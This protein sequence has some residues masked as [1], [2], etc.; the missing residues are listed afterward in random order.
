MK[1]ITTSLLFSSIISTS[2][3]AIP[4]VFYGEDNRHDVADYSDAMFQRY[5]KS[6][7]GMV[8]EG[9]IKKIGTNSYRLNARTL[10]EEYNLCPEVR[11][12]EQK[13]P[14]ECSGFL[15]APDLLL[16]AGHCAMEF[17]F[18]TDFKW[19]FGYFSDDQKITEDDI[20]SCEKI[21]D[22]EVNQL[23]MLDYAIIKL[24]RKVAGRTP[25][26]LRSQGQIERGEEV[27]VIGHPSG[28][29][30]KIADQGFVR[31]HS[32]DDIYFTTNSDTFGINSGSAVFNRTTGLVEGIL[33]RGDQDYAYD[34]Q[35]NCT[36][37][38]QN[39][40]LG[41]RGEDVT[42]VLAI[43]DITKYNRLF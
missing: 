2:C 20:Y 27:V 29:P 19:V 42:S 37:V 32:F 14:M 39:S 35:R 22:M 7:A 8:Y 10:A 24:D 18:C 23:T 6:T 28:L 21:V 1:L 13:A 9:R 26:R 11:F 40:D 15:I 25:L 34:Y 30:T 16:T 38:W 43:P 4:K 12:R 36:A 41:G 33:V 3:F 5:A 17:D 31:S